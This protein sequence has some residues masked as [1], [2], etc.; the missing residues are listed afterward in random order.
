[1]PCQAAVPLALQIGKT[2]ITDKKQMRFEAAFGQRFSQ[3]G[4][5]H[6][7]SARRGIRI[8]SLKGQQTKKNIIRR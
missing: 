2:G 8:R 1:V 5:A 7:Q 6:T 3:M 4:D